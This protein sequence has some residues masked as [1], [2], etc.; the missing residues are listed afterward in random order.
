MR[1]VLFAFAI[2][3]GAQHA[4]WPQ[5]N[6]SAC[7]SA[8]SADARRQRELK[9]P[10]IIEALALKPGARVADIGAG[11]GFYEVLLSKAVAAEGCVYA[12][13]IDEKGAIKRLKERV[14][15]DHL[16]NVE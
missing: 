5:S 13:D 16:G 2:I 12:E 4:A 14:A 3:V 10:E 11:D 1:R 6:S 7:S 8:E 15:K 9:V